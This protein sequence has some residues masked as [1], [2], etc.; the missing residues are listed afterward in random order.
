MVFLIPLLHDSPI[1]SGESTIEFQKI[2]L[3]LKSECFQ[4]LMVV[5]CRDSINFWGNHYNNIL[6]LI[7]GYCDTIAYILEV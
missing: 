6:Y 5:V 7:V 2:K 1:K 3:L 4:H